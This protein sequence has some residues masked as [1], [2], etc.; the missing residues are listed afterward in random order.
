M[1]ITPDQL[2]S[3]LEEVVTE[4]IE[5]RLKAIDQK[6]DALQTSVDKAVKKWDDHLNKEWPVHLKTTHSQIGRRLKR[7]DELLH[8]NTEMLGKAHPNDR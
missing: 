3:A 5:P 4:R 6:I 1:T 8:T 7:H 2:K